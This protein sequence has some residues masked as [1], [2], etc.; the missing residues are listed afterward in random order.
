M[1]TLVRMARA[2]LPS[3]RSSLPALAGPQHHLGKLT[4]KIVLIISLYCTLIPLLLTKC[5]IKRRNVEICLY[6]LDIHK[7]YF[8]IIIN[9]RTRKLNFCLSKVK[10]ELG[11]SLPVLQVNKIILE[12]YSVSDPVGSVSFGR[13]RIHCRK[14]GS[15]SV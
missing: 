14:R 15:G 7:Y 11:Q 4:F 2:G 12:I 8:F 9:L 5:N 1:S 13:I 6:V 10:S 3:T